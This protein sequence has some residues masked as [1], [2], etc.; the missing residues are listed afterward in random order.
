MNSVA[1]VVAAEV[2]AAIAA[3]LGA[4]VAASI[5][6]PI[7]ASIVAPVAA[8]G[9]HRSQLCPNLGCFHIVK[10]LKGSQVN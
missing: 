2:A 6:E 9:Q 10:D 5:V 3:S 4:A 1:A 8:A 7:V